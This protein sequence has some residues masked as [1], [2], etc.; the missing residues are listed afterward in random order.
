MQ[1]L[2]YKLADVLAQGLD[3]TAEEIASPCWDCLNQTTQLL[4]SLFFIMPCRAESCDTHIMC[5]RACLR[6]CISVCHSCQ[7]VN[8]KVLDKDELGPRSGIVW[9]AQLKSCFACNTMQKESCT[10]SVSMTCIVCLSQSNQICWMQAGT[11]FMLTASLNTKLTCIPQTLYWVR[12]VII[13][14]KFVPQ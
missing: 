13:Q 7:V 12:T 1:H 9:P 6:A 4:W 5:V 8:E 3:Q 10:W 2:A 11:K 14:Q